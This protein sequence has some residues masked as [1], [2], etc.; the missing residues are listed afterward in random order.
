MK[1]RSINFFLIGL[2]FVATT[3]SCV[4]LA[5]GAAGVAVGYIAR[6]EGVGV[7]EP[8]GSS[9]SAETYESYDPAVY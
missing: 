9:G 7:V 6:D 8:A 1:P 2:G 4:P 5:V 3:S